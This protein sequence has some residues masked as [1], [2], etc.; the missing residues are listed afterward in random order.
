MEDIYKLFNDYVSNFDMNNDKIQNKYNHTYRVVKY[1]EKIAISEKLNEDDK[2]LA[3]ICALLHDIG[4]FKQVTEYDT[5]HDNLSFDHGDMGYIV[6]KENNYI[7]KYTDNDED[8][9]IV[10]K[11]VKNHNKLIIEDGL[12]DRELYFA[13]LTRDADKLDIFFTQHNEI[14]DNSDTINEKF[15]DSIKNRKQALNEYASNECEWL[16]RLICFIYDLNFKESFNII[17]ENDTLNKKIDLLN[18]VKNIDIN[19]I[20]QEINNYV[21]ERI[22]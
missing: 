21:K 7:D 5:F 16:L 11:A 4:R 18:R 1:A 20:R 13:K 6:L 10:L 2:K 9:S 19:Y 22:D 3:M 12:T 8:K 15:L 17:L 14:K